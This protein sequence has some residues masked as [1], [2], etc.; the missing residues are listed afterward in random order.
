MYSERRAATADRNGGVGG[1]R[2]TADVRQCRQIVAVR[3]HEGEGLDDDFT[4]TCRLWGRV[5]KKVVIVNHL[6]LALQVLSSRFSAHSVLQLDWSLS[7]LMVFEW[8]GH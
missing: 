2:A 3:L 7:E 8:T 4:L 1:G 5:G 6:M